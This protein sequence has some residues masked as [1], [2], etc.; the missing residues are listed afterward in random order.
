[1]VT[2]EMLTLTLS[3]GAPWGFRLQGGGSFP[4]EVA[5]VR[6]NSHSHQ[7]GLKEGDVVVSLNGHSL[8]GKSHQSAMEIVDMATH[9][10]TFQVRRPSGS[11]GRSMSMEPQQRNLY[12]GHDN[13]APG[14]A[15]SSRGYYTTNEGNRQTVVHSD[16]YTLRNPDGRTVSNIVTEQRTTTRYGGGS[17]GM[18]PAV[19]HSSLGSTEHKS[20]SP[21]RSPLIW[22]PPSQNRANIQKSQSLLDISFGHKKTSL[23]PVMWQ[24]RSVSPT[25]GS[26]GRPASVQSGSLDRVSTRRSSHDSRA[27]KENMDPFILREQKKWEATHVTEPKYDPYNINRAGGMK[28][29]PPKMDDPNYPM[30]ELPRKVEWT[31]PKI[32]VQPEPIPSPIK[33]KG[34]PVP[35]KPMTPSSPVIHF[36]PSERP[37]AGVSSHRPGMIRPPA[38]PNLMPAPPPPPLPPSPSENPR[39]NVVSI[40]SKLESTQPG[41]DEPDPA[42]RPGHLHVFQPKVMFTPDEDSG[43]ASPD[44]LDGHSDISAHRKKLF[45]DSAFY[46]DATNRYPTIDEQMSMCKKIAQSL[47]SFANNRARGARMFAKRKRKANKWIHERGFGSEFS[48]STGDVADLNDLDSELYYDE[49]GNKPLFTFRIPKVASQVSDG[50]RMSLSKQEFERLRLQAP[51]VDHHGVSPNTCFNIAADLHKGGKNR[52]A[53]LFQKR[54]QRVEK[55]VIDDTNVLRSP[56]STK[57]DFIVQNP[58]QP[59]PEK[60]PWNAAAQGDMN[61]AF[62]PHQYNQMTL[63]PRHNLEA[64]NQPKLIGGKNFNKKAQGWQGFGPGVQQQS[65]YRDY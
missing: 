32:N 14:M 28:Y 22:Q 58:P 25:P 10:I 50:Q 34:P 8:A 55:F 24:P 19:S 64:D 35:A 41:Y 48:S 56:T 12:V 38:Q 30:F 1:M 3:G 53:K 37:V 52:G 26:H 16:Q 60:S 62:S 47:T 36:D 9:T 6:R 5:K 29:A 39:F 57:L 59:S 31:P 11:H 63:G 65:Y 20:R 2:G 15:T 42:Q 18:S 33:K 46:D 40:Q 54:Q 49:G 27:S 45:S 61:R 4:L 43:M 13:V 21:N 17:G 51:K 7:A 44:F 23:S